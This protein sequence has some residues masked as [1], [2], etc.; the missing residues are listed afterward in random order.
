MEIL[1]AYIG[2]VVI[3]VFNQKLFKAGF[4]VIDDILSKKEE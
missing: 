3:L 4:G 1:F 2:I